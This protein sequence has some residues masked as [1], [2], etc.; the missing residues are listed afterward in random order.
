MRNAN[1]SHKIPKMVREVEKGLGIHIR[2]QITNKVNQ[3]FRLVSQIIT[4]S[5]IKSTDY[6]S[7]NHAHA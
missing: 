7:S 5:S 2:D 3:F 4:P 1:K 6:F